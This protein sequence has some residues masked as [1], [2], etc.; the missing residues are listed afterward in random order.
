MLE[1]I[2]NIV[3]DYQVPPLE[4]WLYIGVWAVVML[5]IG[6]LVFTRFSKNI[7]EEL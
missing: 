7:V 3:Y 2:R 6:I 5:V 4:N 1:S